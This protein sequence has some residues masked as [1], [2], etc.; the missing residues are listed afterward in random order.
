MPEFISTTD[1]I[2]NEPSKYKMDIKILDQNEPGYK[3]QEIQPGSVH[4]VRK[5]IKT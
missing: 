3:S 1:R 2:L 5:I 4:M